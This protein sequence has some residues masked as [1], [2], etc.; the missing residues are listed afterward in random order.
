MKNNLLND[1]KVLPYI[2]YEDY[3]KVKSFPI[4]NITGLTDQIFL[5]KMGNKFYIN[6]D[7]H[8]LDDLSINDLIT[9]ILDKVGVVISIYK[10]NSKDFLSYSAMFLCDFT[11]EFYR[12][13]T[14]TENHIKK[15]IL[16][17]YTDEYL[18]DYVLKN[19]TMFTDY[20]IEISSKELEGFIISDFNLSAE[21]HLKY[22][23]TSL[24]LRS[25]EEYSLTDINQ[26]YLT[27]EI[28]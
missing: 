25:F 9:L 1:F 28:L 23:A 3:V 10:E 12:I 20:G 13:L 24:N 7:M 17:E 27:E 11:T 21:I 5:K 15:S 2:K 18:N 22:F 6:N 26:M 14:T 4:L 8:I 16:K 19:Y